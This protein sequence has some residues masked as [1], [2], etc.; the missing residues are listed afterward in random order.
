MVIFTNFAM[1]ARFSIKL[2]MGAGLGLS[3]QISSGEN[4]LVI[5]KDFAMGGRVVNTDF[6]IGGQGYSNIY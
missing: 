1:G 4:H 3:I 2:S 6:N 5:H